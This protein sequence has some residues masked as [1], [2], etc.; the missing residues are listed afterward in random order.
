MWWNQLKKAKNIDDNRIS[1]RQFKGYFQEKYLSEQYYERKMKEFFELKLGT[2]TMEEYEKWFFELLNY[3]EFIKDDKVK[4]QRSLSGLPSFYNDK[5]QYDN[6][7]TLEETIRRAKYLYEQSKG[8]PFFQKA[9]NDKMKDKKDQRQKGF[10]PPF[11]RNNFQANQ[12]GQVA[13]NEHETIDSFG[14]RSR[15]QLVQCWEC[16]ENHLYRDCPHKGE[17][18]RIVHNI[19]EAETVEDMGMSISRIY[20]TLDNKQVEYQSPMIEV[21]GK[22]NNEPITILIDSRASHTYIN[23]NIAERFHLQRSKHKKSWLVQLATW[24]KRKINEWVKYCPIDMNGLNK[25][26][27][28]NIIPLDSYDCLIGMDWLEK[29]HVV[30]DCYNNTITCL[31]EEG[32]QGK[33]QGIL[34]VVTIREISAM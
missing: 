5:I 4:I 23:A 25:K 31:D 3:V 18:M 20:A 9:L 13:Q 33:I 6:P 16:G 19:H 15:Q 1:W 7:K 8:R 10:K 30:L 34:R 26:V 11:F 21:E 14:K 29:H 2:M 17:R 32:Q 24:A 28:V 12:H 27:D 22:I